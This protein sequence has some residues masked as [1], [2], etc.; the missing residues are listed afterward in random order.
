MDDPSKKTN[1]GLRTIDLRPGHGEIL[2]PGETIDIKR[3][4]PLTLTDRRVWNVLIGHSFGPEMARQGYEWTIPLADL[5]GTHKGNER[6]AHTVERLMRTVVRVKLPNGKTQ[7]FTLLGGNDMDDEDRAGAL[8]TYSFDKRLVAILRNSTTFG[9]LEMAVMLALPS[10]Y[11]L[12]LYEHV[13]KRVRLRH[14]CTDT[15][16]LDELRE[17]LGVPDGKLKARGSLNQKALFPAIKEINAMAS[18]T[19]TVWPVKTGRKI[20]DVK[21]GWAP[22]DVEGLKA[23]YREV[24][25]TRVGRRARIRGEVEEYLN[26]VGSA[27][28]DEVPE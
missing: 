1:G 20:T 21:I 17:I 14:K 27:P 24:H 25:S 2:K 7:R 15:Y 13:A 16:T 8:L 9:R 26:P 19:V 22:K 23:A 18:F 11:S 12:S 4:S 5:R 6:I 10:K 3:T 28:D